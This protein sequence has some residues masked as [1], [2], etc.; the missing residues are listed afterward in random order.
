M[1]AVNLI[2]RDARRGGFSASQLGVSHFIVA[3]MV[4]ALG[5]VTVYVL[6]SN[7]VASR[8]SQLADLKQ[9]VTRMQAEVARLQ[10]YA[11]FEKLAQ[12]RAQT[13]REIASSRFDWHGALSDLSKVVPANT[14]LQSL[15]AT[16]APG[17]TSGGSSA[18]SS[19][20]VVRGA[21]D[22]PAFELRGCT[23]TQDQVAQLMSRLRLVNGVT[24]VTLE[25]SA[26]PAAAQS[27]S[28][29]STTTSGTGCP[30]NGPS[31]D[32]VVFFQPVP[33][34]LAMAPSG[35]TGLPTTKAPGAAK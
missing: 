28:S 34:A 9:Q 5:F 22:A 18:G 3:L 15:V 20:G 21:L 29:V 4:V 6:S 25:D 2:P 14:S 10:S 33:G 31:F 32:M 11:Q 35:T 19:G 30:A 7:T 26:K 27:A 1:R 8:K 17:T 24:R 13:V 12:E 16:V 23:G